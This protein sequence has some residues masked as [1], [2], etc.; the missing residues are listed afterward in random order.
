MF[1]IF[2]LNVIFV[3][4]HSLYVGINKPVWDSFV[5]RFIMNLIGWIA[6]SAVGWAI[7][8]GIHFIVKYW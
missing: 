4:L 6:I 7:Y 3:L 2:V 5:E 8:A 1:T